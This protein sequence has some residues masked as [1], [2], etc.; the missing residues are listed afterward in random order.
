MRFYF[1]LSSPGQGTLFGQVIALTFTRE[2]DHVT[3]HHLSK[4]S[5]HGE[6]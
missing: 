3:L 6:M 2:F 5:E 4:P 1:Y